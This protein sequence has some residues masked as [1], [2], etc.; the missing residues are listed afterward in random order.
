MAGPRRSLRVELIA[1]LAVLLMMAVVSLSLA[2][3]LLGRQRHMDQERARLA[4]HAHGLAIVVGPLLDTAAATPGRPGVEQVLRGSVGTLG[5]VAIEVWRVGA[6]PYATVS[7]GLP[8]DADP[9]VP[10]QTDRRRSIET[11]DGFWVVDEPIRTFGPAEQRASLVLRV[12]AQPTPWTRTDDWKEI[13]LLAGGVGAVLLLLGGLLVE[14][15]VLKPMRAVRNAAKQVGVGNLGASVPED[16]P[17]EVRQLA[18]S[19]N[20]MTA[21]LREQVRENEAQ[22]QRLVR[23]EQL[24]TVGR[25]AAGMAHEVGN[26]LAAILGYVELL[27]DPRSEP[28]LTE[29]QRSLLERTR[30]QLG[31]IQGTL[32]QLLEYSRPASRELEAVSVTAALRRLMAM[33]KHDPRCQDVE[34]VVEGDDAL[35]ATA[36]PAL[37]DQVIQN[38]VVNASRAAKQPDDDVAPRV[39]LT[40]KPDGDERVRIDVT[41]NGP[42]VAEDDRDQLFEPF[43]SKA[44]AGEGTGLGL[45][46]SLGLVESMEGELTYEGDVKPVQSE[47]RPGARF[48]VSLPAATPN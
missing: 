22:R 25:V 19:F 24:A 1:T 39:A 20:S 47:A 9:P 38:L 27:L 33:T 30:T 5:I 34:L 13:A 43:F 11:E 42:G 18:S 16:G 48:R 21:S 35:Q 29:E 23:A 26:P 6:R 8:P 3:E 40:V 36:D 7:L 4:D 12:S 28:P 32:G 31:R 14:A 37:L 15:Q 44:P 41:D 2:G 17:A 10:G 45:A 46:I